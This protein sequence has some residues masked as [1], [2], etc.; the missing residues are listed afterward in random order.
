MPRK[1]PDSRIRRAR[2]PAKLLS[3]I[4][5]ARGTNKTLTLHHI[6]NQEGKRVKTFANPNTPFFYG[7]RRPPLRRDLIQDRANRYGEVPFRSC[8]LYTSDAADE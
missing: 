1:R 5:K 6:Y 3:S 7:D 4:R 2:A 8:L